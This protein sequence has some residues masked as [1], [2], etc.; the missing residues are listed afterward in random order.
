MTSLV[1]D[2][3]SLSDEQRLELLVELRRVAAEVEAR[4]L[5]VFNAMD[6]AAQRSPFELDKD[7]VAEDI[8]ATCR[9]SSNAAGEWLLFA[10]EMKRMPGLLAMLLRGE[11]TVMHAR[12]AMRQALLLSDEQVAAFVERVAADALVQS[13]GQ[14][15]RT[16]QRAALAVGADPVERRKQAY[17]ERRVASR[18][19]GDGMGELYG[20]LS[21]PELAAMMAR[22]DAEAR[23]V[24]PGDERTL[25]QKRADALVGFVLGDNPPATT[26]NVVT[27]AESTLAGRDDEPAELARFGTIA[28]E[29]ARELADGP[30]V[31]IRV[32]TT[33]STGLLLDCG[34]GP[35]APAPGH[36]LDY[37]RDTYTP[38]AA[39]DRYVRA[40]DV[41]CRFPG[42]TYPAKHA[43][44]DHIIAWTDGGVTAAWNLQVLCKR[45]HHLKHEGGW[46]V[47][48]RLDG[49]TVW[50]SRLGQTYEVPPHR[51]V[52]SGPDPPA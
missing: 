6:E 31:R 42:C 49:T 50:L 19:A 45:H 39:L 26:V 11:I 20:F 52:I 4:T 8:A 12:A 51:Y 40:R 7:W 36:L 28:A 44:I 5:D 23:K 30:N 24:S 37:G 22:V 35:N 17:A 13:V 25:E 43:D 18:P 15:G 32:F 16:C 33:D 46:R 47:E 29:Q 14:F 27:V 41:T 34:E 38:P 1:V 21:A 48:R 2:P 9:I 3:R 10:R